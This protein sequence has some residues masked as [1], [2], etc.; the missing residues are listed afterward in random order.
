MT[1]GGDGEARVDR[2]S[3][4]WW[5]APLC[6]VVTT[7]VAV[8]VLLVPRLGAH[9]AVPHHLVLAGAADS[10][11][12]TTPSPRPRKRPTPSATPS[13]TTTPRVNPT[14]EVVQPQRPV[15]T[16]PSED[17]HEQEPGDR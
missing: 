16:V 6:V 2:R 13:P 8:T 12:T 3:R 10:A 15:V 17:G 11:A 4:V 1:V 5:L 9:V 14:T 7:A